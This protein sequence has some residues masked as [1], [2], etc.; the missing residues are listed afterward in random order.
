[1]PELDVVADSSFNESIETE[2]LKIF[3]LSFINDNV[4]GWGPNNMPEKY[5]DL[6]YQ[7]FSKSDRIGKV[8]KLKIKLI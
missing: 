7:K 1:M 2:G 8:T 4:D 6:P 3:T 5:K